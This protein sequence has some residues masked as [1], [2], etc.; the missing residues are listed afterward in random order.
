[1]CQ[2]KIPIWIKCFSA[3]R[4]FIILNKNVSV[5]SKLFTWIKHVPVVL[6]SF[7]MTKF[8]YFSS[9]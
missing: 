2:Y 9:K 5:I 7:H 8:D 3:I 1:M 6:Y 4:L